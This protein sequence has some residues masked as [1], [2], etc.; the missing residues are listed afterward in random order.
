MACNASP[1]PGCVVVYGDYCDTRIGVRTLALGLVGL[2]KYAV[3]PNL[4]NKVG[5][6]FSD[7]LALGFIGVLV[8]F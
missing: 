3:Q 1:N 8:L 6:L 7:Y 5:G 4:L 2:G